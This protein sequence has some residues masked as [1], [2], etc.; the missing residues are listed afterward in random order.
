M[1]KQKNNFLWLSI[2]F[3]LSIFIAKQVKI[4]D[5][6]YENNADI[7]VNKIRL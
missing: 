6:K 1:K 5:I 2:E 7:F 3:V 4:P